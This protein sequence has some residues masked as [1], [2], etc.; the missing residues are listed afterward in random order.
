MQGAEKIFA[1]PA[2]RPPRLANFN[3]HPSPRV[4]G[5][6]V[7]NGPYDWD[8]PPRGHRLPARRLGPGLDGR[9]RR[10]LAGLVGVVTGAVVQVHAGRSLNAGAASGVCA[11]PR[12][13]E[14]IRT[15]G[16]L[17]NLHALAQADRNKLIKVDASASAHAMCF[18][19]AGHR[20]RCGSFE[21]LELHLIIHITARFVDETTM[22]RRVINCPKERWHRA[23]TAGLL[24]PSDVSQTIP[25]KFAEASSQRPSIGS[26][27]AVANY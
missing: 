6:L 19:A 14:A 7:T 18:V 15:L 21:W 5:A 2:A 24:C 8:P 25:I 9:Q 22:T 11:L 12:A 23:T 16:L 26:T 3:I 4:G 20:F 10:S 1:I 27:I 17:G 13:G